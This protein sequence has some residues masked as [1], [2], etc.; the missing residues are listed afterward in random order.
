MTCCGT[1]STAE[2]CIAD[3]LRQTE[4]STVRK[5]LLK[6]LHTVSIASDT[7]INYPKSQPVA[8]TSTDMV[9]KEATSVPLTPPIA[10]TSVGRVPVKAVE[11]TST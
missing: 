10:Y 4:S 2:A 1:R 8:S 11:G 3:N 9:L 6:L 5:R 7:H